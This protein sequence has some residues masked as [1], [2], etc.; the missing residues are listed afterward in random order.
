MEHIFR[1]WIGMHRAMI[2]WFHAAHHVTK[3]T[4]FGGDHVNLYGEIYTQ[5]DEDLDG[6][7]EKGIGLTGDETLADP[8]S[9]LSMAAGLLAQQPASAN[10]DA[11]TIA[12]NGLQVIKYYVD[13]IEKIYAQFESVGMSLGLDD[14]LQGH[15]NQYETYVYLLQQRSRTVSLQKETKMVMTESELRAE[16]RERL[17]NEFSIM[18]TVGKI[19]APIVEEI[20]EKIA[21]FIIGIFG[22][23]TDGFMGKTIVNACGNIT[24]GDLKD[25]AFGDM[26]I[27]TFSRELLEG[28]QETM[29][30]N[31][32]EMFGVDPDGF[33]AEAIEEGIVN[34]FSKDS[35]LSKEVAKL[36][37]KEI[38]GISFF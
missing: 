5:L 29:L 3:G 24:L 18:G 7:V 13:F 30:E 9:S 32:P 1:Q 31:I 10:Q 6:I 19:L 21:R 2:A 26:Q 15:A 34:S 22:V 12:A 16:I 11:E 8:V 35:D 33:F 28:M 27:E 23:D 17:L 38:D 36:I 14:L 37:A 4:G 20:K 25:M